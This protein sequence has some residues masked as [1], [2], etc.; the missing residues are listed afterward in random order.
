MSESV[1]KTKPGDL[2]K[3]RFAFVVA[4]LRE[5][6]IQRSF[7]QEELNHWTRRLDLLCQEVIGLEDS[8]PLE[9]S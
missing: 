4:A 2:T 9:Q 7:H 1:T 3:E 6:S 8:F 5:A